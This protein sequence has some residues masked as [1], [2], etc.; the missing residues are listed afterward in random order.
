MVQL[1]RDER[2]SGTSERNYSSSLTLGGKWGTK[3]YQ[4]PHKGA[5]LF[6]WIG[7]E[8]SELLRG[9][10]LAAWVGGGAPTLKRSHC[11][12]GRG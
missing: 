9:T 5:T 1:W 8:R 12:Q 11:R 2:G 7:R 6:T 4:K 10:I 3:E